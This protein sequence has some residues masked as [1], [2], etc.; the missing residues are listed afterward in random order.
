[1]STRRRSCRRL[2]RLPIS[3]EPVV[4][5]GH[6]PR[7][8]GLARRVEQNY[9]IIAKIQASRFLVPTGFDVPRKSILVHRRSQSLDLQMIRCEARASSAFLQAVSQRRDDRPHQ[10]GA[11]SNSG[12]RRP[13]AT[14]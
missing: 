4:N 2:P 13:E 11:A 12:N 5:L 6:A 7:I 14:S 8:P 1:M 9:E 3:R 10:R